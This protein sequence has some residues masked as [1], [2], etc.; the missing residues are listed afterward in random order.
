MTLA[1]PGRSP[2]V[3]R[4]ELQGCSSRNVTS[5]VFARTVYP[6]RKPR[7]ACTCN[8]RGDRC[9]NLALFWAPV[10]LGLGTSAP[11]SVPAPARRLAPVWSAVSLRARPAASR[12]YRVPACAPARYPEPVCR[13]TP[14]PV[15]GVA[16]AQPRAPTD[17]R[18]R[19]SRPPETA[20]LGRTP[21]PNA[22][23]C[24]PASPVPAIS[25]CV[26]SPA[27]P[28]TEGDVGGRTVTDETSGVLWC[29]PRI[30]PFGLPFVMRLL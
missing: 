13:A 3:P 20:S 22:R 8:R 28:V 16:G 12:P 11:T 27:R 30:R 9:R 10:L 18:R 24:R 4:A 19:P 14:D 23:E 26:T 29:S 2:Q 7:R 17:A 1:A 21:H 25:L 5:G 6:N 15:C